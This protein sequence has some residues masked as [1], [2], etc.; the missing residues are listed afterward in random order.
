MD[1]SEFLQ[2]ADAAMYAILAILDGID[3]DEVDTD[4][5]AGVLTMEFADGSKSVMNRQGAAH[6]VWLAAGATA[7]HFAWDEEAGR[8]RDTKGRGALEEVLGSVLSSRLGR[9][10]NL[11]S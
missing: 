4:L 3:P 1:D 9:T 6:Q 5:A 7:W 8:W 2:R 11:E 10:I